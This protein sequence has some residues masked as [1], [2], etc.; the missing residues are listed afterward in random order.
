[1]AS[2]SGWDQYPSRN[3]DCQIKFK[4]LE[5]ITSSHTK[6]SGFVMGGGQIEHSGEQ[7]T[8]RARVIDWAQA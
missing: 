6:W 2:H 4:L 8:P 1:M 7:E 3:R 5:M